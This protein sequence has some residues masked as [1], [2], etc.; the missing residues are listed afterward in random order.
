MKFHLESE[1]ILHTFLHTNLVSNFQIELNTLLQI[2]LEKEKEE[3]SKL[4]EEIKSLKEQFNIFVKNAIETQRNNTKIMDNQK[5]KIEYLEG[6]LP[7]TKQLSKLVGNE[8]NELNVE[9]LSGKMN[10][11]NKNISDL[12]LRQ[13]LFENTC[14]DGK[15]LWKIDNISK[16]INQAIKGNVT[17]LHSA[18]AFTERYGY[19]FCGRLY[20]NGDG[21]GKGTHVSL[22]IVLMKSEHDNLLSWPFNREITLRLVNQVYF[23]E[24]IKEC[25]HSDVGSSSFMQPKKEMNIASGCPLLITKDIFLGGGFVKDDTAFIEISIS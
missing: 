25:F 1:V 10:V 21:V 8:N 18:P 22:F 20:L 23:N 14:H 24:D 19:K 9:V 13:Q 5:E 2:Q 6:C 3:E 15:I 17:A 11:L 4:E 12:K 7:S 16:R